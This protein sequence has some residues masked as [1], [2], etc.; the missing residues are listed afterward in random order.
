MFVL[1]AYNLAFADEVQKAVVQLQALE[2]DAYQDVH[3]P[4]AQ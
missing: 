2:D 3:A 4:M 1:N